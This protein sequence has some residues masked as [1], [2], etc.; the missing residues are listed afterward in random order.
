MEDNKDKDIFQKKN[1][2]LM[3]EILFLLVLPLFCNRESSFGQSELGNS[4]YNKSAIK[5]EYLKIWSW[6]SPYNGDVDATLIGKIVDTYGE[7]E[8]KKTVTYTDKKILLLDFLQM[9]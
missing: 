6:A 3:V 4:Q 1:K 9:Q 2:R 7:V 5:A 8:C